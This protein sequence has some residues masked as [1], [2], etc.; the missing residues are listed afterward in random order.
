MHL[1]KETEFRYV[2]NATYGRIKEDTDRAW[3]NYSN[4]ERTLTRCQMGINS[5]SVLATTAY[6]DS[7]REAC[8][9][10]WY[11]NGCVGGKEMM[12]V[13]PSDEH[14]RKPHISQVQE[15]VTTY[16]W[17]ERAD[18]LNAKVSER[19]EIQAV[20]EKVKML[21]KQADTGATLQEQG[22]KY[23]EEHGFEKSSDALRAVIQGAELERSS[24]GLPTALVKI[25]Q[26]DDTQLSDVITNL[27]KKANPDESSQFLDAEFKE[28]DDAVENTETPEQS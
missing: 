28:T 26:M 16:G 18:V 17:H 10:A 9:L 25:S 4:L 23:L 15:W 7:Y 22:M 2:M 20:E 11:Q 14:G 6:S 1:T 13:L 21:I 27:L 3:T 5:K 24:R 19:V 12:G 8:F